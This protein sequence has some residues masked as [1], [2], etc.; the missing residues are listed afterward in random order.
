M[1]HVYNE[2]VEECLQ[3]FADEEAHGVLWRSDGK[4]DVSSF[5]ECSCRLWDDSGLGDAMEKPG[6]IYSKDIDDKLRRLHIVLRKVDYRQP[7]DNVLQDPNLRAARGMAG[8][9]LEE[10]RQF[11]DDAAK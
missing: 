6:V 2:I 5:I 1:I 11:G 8:A 10:L 9:L 7:V 3:E 4:S